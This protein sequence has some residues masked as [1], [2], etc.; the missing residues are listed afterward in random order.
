MQ[1]LAQNLHIETPHSSIKDYFRMRFKSFDDM[2]DFEDKVMMNADF[3]SS[4]VS[5]ADIAFFTST[6]D[7]TKFDLGVDGKINGLVNNLKATQLTVKAGQATYLKGDFNL[8]GLPDW[9]NTFLELNFDQVASNKKDLD[10]LYNRFSGTTNRKLP[11]VI[12]KFGNVNFKGKFTGLQNDFVAYGDFKTQLGHFQ[13]DVNLKISKA[14]KPTYSGNVKLYDF[15][16]GILADNADLGRI[17]AVADVNGSGDEFKTL[18]EKVKAKITYI[19]YN[20]YRYT[21][22]DVDGSVVKKFFSGSVDINDK[23]V[24]LALKGSADLNPAMPVYNLEG[25]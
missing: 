1:I 6:L 14:G 10:Y 19:D 17:T 11:D 4:Q 2:G 24:N 8:R 22:V 15:D 21:N 7:K 12:G 3:K 13:T 18:S 20:N 25:S 23:N 5:S 9:N 16:L